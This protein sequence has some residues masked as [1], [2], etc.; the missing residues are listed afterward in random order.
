MLN[1]IMLKMAG[2]SK[3][4]LAKKLGIKAGFSVKLV[5]APEYYWELFTDVPEDIRVNDNAIKAHDFIHFFTKDEKELARVLP[6][7]KKEIVQDGMIWV[8]WPKKSAKV[9][10]DITEQD[11]RDTALKIGLVDIKVCAVDEVWSGLKL[12]IPVTDRK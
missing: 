3:T 2:Y 8:S 7:L 11:V 6:V 4:P 1:S 10:C 9:A 5:N 12:V